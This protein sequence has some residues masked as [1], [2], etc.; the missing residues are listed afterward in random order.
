LFG[1][2]FCRLLHQLNVL[3]ME[4]YSASAGKLETIV[5]LCLVP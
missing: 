3:V 5:C 4:R 2:G 1:F